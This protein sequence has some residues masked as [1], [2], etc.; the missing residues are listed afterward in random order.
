MTKPN[1]RA[2]TGKDKLSK[3]RPENF[4]HFFVGDFP[5]LKDGE[6]C[7]L[8]TG[9]LRHVSHPCEGC[10]RIAGNDKLTLEYYGI[11]TAKVSKGR[12]R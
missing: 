12:A 4:K 8:H 3:V 7:G 5:P 1:K 9:C 2:W 6:A 10:G 11:P